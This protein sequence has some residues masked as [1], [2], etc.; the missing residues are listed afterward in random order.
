MTKA[1][2]ILT[3]L[4]PMTLVGLI[5]SVISYEML[6]ASPGS[7]YSNV[8]QNIEYAI[9][10]VGIFALSVEACKAASN[11]DGSVVLDQLMSLSVGLIVVVVY[12]IGF[13]QLYGGTPMGPIPS[14]H[15]EILTYRPFLYSSIV[16]W[17]DIINGFVI[18]RFN[19]SR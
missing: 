7:H 19:R 11:G 1:Y 5:A 3:S 15:L 6:L 13:M 17:L 14:E 18:A 16:V 10:I 12:I 2:R 8:Q 4:F 9:Y